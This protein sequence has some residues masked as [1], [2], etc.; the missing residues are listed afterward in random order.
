MGE[1]DL[2]VHLDWHESSYL[3]RALYHPRE[4]GSKEILEEF[5]RKVGAARMGMANDAAAK[6]LSA[7]E[8]GA[9]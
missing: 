4:K 6:A 2:S 9:P 8:G 5:A 7:I 1:R 3:L